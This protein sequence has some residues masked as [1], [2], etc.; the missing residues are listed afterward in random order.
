MGGYGAS[1]DPVGGVYTCF[2]F[3]LAPK[4]GYLLWEIDR[5]HSDVT[6]NKLSTRGGWLVKKGQK[7]FNVFCERPLIAVAVLLITVSIM[8]DSCFTTK[9]NSFDNSH[10][11]CNLQ[12]DVKICSVHDRYFYFGL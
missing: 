12:R 9:N 5:Y 11:Y 6:V 4:M 10:V 2:L 7:S 1:H 8:T 3:N